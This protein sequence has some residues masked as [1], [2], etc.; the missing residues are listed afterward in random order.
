MGATTEIAWTDATFNPW[1]GC[2]RA[3]AGCAHCY[4]ETLAARWGHRVWGPT[5]PRRVFGDAHWREP[6]RWARDAAR[7]GVRRRVFVAS[8]ADWLEDRRELDR[9]RA[10]LGA[11][12]EAAPEL[13]W[14]LVSKRMQN[15]ARLSPWRDGRYPDHVWLGTTVEH[16]ATAAPRLDALCALDAPVRFVSAEPLLGAIDLTPWLTRLDW[17]IVGG[18]SGPR[19]REMPLEAAE[20]IVRD[21]HEAGVAVFVK[22]DSGARTGQQGR[23]ADSWWIRQFPTPRQR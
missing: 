16:Q 4:A 9:E 21:C 14:L 2:A 20:R 7:D 1:W 11:L 8:M 22:Q 18:E 10:R 3:S 5:A 6:L 13:D 17:V 19:R 15:A 23:I 12:V